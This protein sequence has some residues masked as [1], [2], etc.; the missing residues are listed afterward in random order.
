MLSSASYI[1]SQCISGMVKKKNCFERKKEEA[2]DYQVAVEF[3]R[4][5]VSCII[6]SRNI[7]C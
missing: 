6:V 1:Q 3:A 2:C 5:L 4:E 7:H